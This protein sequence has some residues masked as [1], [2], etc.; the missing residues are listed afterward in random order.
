MEC[1]IDEKFLQDWAVFLGKIPN[2]CGVKVWERNEH[3]VTESQRDI[4]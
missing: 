1:A 3:R 4:I 2:E